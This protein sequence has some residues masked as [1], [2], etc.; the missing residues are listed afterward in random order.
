MTTREREH[1][2]DGQEMPIVIFH[3]DLSPI[4]MKF[5]LQRKSFAHTLTHICAIVGGVYVIFSI[6]NRILLAFCDFS[7]SDKKGV[8]ASG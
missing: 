6:L 1:N 2:S 7:A 8:A 5:T 3:Y 4:T